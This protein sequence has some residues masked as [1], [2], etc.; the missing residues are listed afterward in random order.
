MRV[1][2]CLKWSR[3]FTPVIVFLAMSLGVPGPNLRGGDA[4]SDQPF[5]GTPT[6]NIP[7]PES[8]YRLKAGDIIE[9]RFFFHPELSDQVQVRPDGW[10]SL[11][12]V[13]DIQFAG[14][15]VAEAEAALEEVY[16]GDL[17]NPSISIQIR[18][19]GAQTIYVTGEVLRPGMQSLVSDKTLMGAIGEAGGISH[20]GHRKKVLVI[21]KGDDGLPVLTEVRL[22]D[23]GDPTAD[24]MM[25]LQPQDVVIVPESKI[26]RADR[27]IDQNIRKLIPI[28]LS[29]QY[30]YLVNA[31][32]GG[33]SY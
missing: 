7:T 2:A 28:H 27:W 15:T 3:A 29:A 18:G 33:L 4:T 10:L 21:R 22:V 9:I 25:L 1:A 20:T 14:R 32:D 11:P 6:E 5:S 8:R 16:E 23:R 26:A 17:R 30:T 24:S 13:G 19:Y 31:R 12:L